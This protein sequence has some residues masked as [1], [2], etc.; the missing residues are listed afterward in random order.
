MQPGCL[1]YVTNDK[2]G[3]QKAMQE[4][5]EKGH[6][7]NTGNRMIGVV[8]TPLG[9]P[10]AILT[11]TDDAN[12]GILAIIQKGE[13]FVNWGWVPNTPIKCVELEN[14]PTILNKSVA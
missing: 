12:I 13:L 7:K 14:F 6:L 11:I 9:T 10:I 5:E 4:I 3:D 8:N 2:P 1:V